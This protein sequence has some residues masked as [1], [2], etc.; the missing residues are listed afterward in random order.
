[1]KLEIF[2][3][4]IFLLILYFL[5]FQEDLTDFRG[6]ILKIPNFDYS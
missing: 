4:K 6:Q 1:M 3:I 5:A 2:L